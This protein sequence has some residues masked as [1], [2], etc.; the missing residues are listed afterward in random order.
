MSN[1]DWFKFEN[2]D[3]DFPFYNNNPK[4]SKIGWLVLFFALFV[5]MLLQAFSES[6]LLGGFLF[7]AVTLIAILYY[8]RWDIKAII[9]KP[10]AKEVGLAVLLLVI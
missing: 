3:Y 7:C 5:A 10:K 4:I 6:E 2:K 9:R 1:V 8:L